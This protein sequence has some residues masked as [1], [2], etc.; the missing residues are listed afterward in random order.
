MAAAPGQIPG[1]RDYSCPATGAQH[2]MPRDPGGLLSRLM[3]V[4]VAFPFAGAVSCEA[5]HVSQVHMHGV[6]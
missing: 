3:H 6:H 1:A 5:E 4:A 2:S